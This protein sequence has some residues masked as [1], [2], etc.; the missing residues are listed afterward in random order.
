MMFRDGNQGNGCYDAS[1]SYSEVS[2]IHGVFHI[3]VDMVMLGKYLVITGARQG[4]LQG[5]GAFRFMR[6]QPRCTE[7]CCIRLCT[8]G[9]LQF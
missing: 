9:R 7:T 5:N 3:E 4:V 1:L 2:K 6:G 8:E